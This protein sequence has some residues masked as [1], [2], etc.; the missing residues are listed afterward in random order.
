MIVRNP[1]LAVLI[2]AISCAICLAAGYRIGH[3]EREP[4]TRIS[5][6][7]GWACREIVD[8]REQKIQ[9]FDEY[10]KLAEGG[11]PV[12]FLHF[13]LGKRSECR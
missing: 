11:K 7:P 5:Q 1:G 8:L 4:M 3:D 6:L 9:M 12:T 13:R 2:V 10:V